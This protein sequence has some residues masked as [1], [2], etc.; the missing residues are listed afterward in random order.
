MGAVTALTL[1]TAHHHHHHYAS[2]DLVGLAIGSAA[3]WFGVP[4][5]GEPLLIAAGIIAARHHLAI[6]SVVLVA[7]GAANVGGVAGWV[8]GIK[9]GRGL[10]T[11][12]GP[13]LKMRLWA[14][15]RGERVFERA[16]VI[17]VLLAPAWLVGIHRVRFSLFAPLQVLGSAM[18]AA[19]YGLGAYY[20]GPPVVD[21]L[22]DAG[23]ATIVALIVLIVA[24]SYGETRRRHRHHPDSPD[25]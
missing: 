16:T 12:P 15:E 8:L 24:V 9:A 13:L 5:P 1:N 23:T 17:A 3:S 14:L 22:K 19:F 20:A 21:L 6:S 2:V 11:R 25:P 4:G 10:V 7:F 18:W